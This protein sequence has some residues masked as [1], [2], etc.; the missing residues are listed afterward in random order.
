[1]TTV[2]RSRSSTTASTSTGSSRSTAPRFRRTAPSC[3]PTRT[4]TPATAA[5]QRAK[6]DFVRPPR[7][8]TLRDGS[9]PS[10]R[11]STRTTSS[12]AGTPENELQLL[13]NGP[14]TIAEINAT[15]GYTTLTANPDYTWGPSPK[16]ESITVRV[17]PDMQAQI[18]ALEN[19][20]ISIASGQPTAD[21]A[22]ASAMLVSRVSS[23]RVL[24][25][26]RTS[27]STFRSATAVRSTPRPT[28][29]TRR[30]LLP[31]ARRS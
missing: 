12:T 3:S 8:R 5:T 31:F 18:T 2:V 10:P 17:I 21:I 22:R 11:P 15:D 20:E 6:D 24:L 4:S 13:S 23:T 19:Q 27:T 1:M 9:R 7:T 25:R 29:A 16:Y 30:R 26:A 28:V 14:Y